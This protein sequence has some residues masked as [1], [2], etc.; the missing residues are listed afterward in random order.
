MRKNRLMLAMVT[1][2]TLGLSS[3][4][5][6][7][8]MGGSHGNMPM[9]QNATQSQTATMNR[10]QMN[11]TVPPADSLVNQ[12]RQSW[13]MMSGNFD[14]LESHFRQ[15]MQI[16]DMKTLKA[17]MQKHY[18]MMQQMHSYMN[19]QQGMYQNMMSMMSSG[20]QRGMH[21]MHA[22]MSTDSTQSATKS[23]HNR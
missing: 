7:Q 11:G 3:M 12:M 1:I 19:N 6:A 15:M 2:L 9:G 21:G 14:K 4:V 22:M 20:Q 17:E 16:Q 18:E 10:G 8:M 5:L 23:Q 13:G